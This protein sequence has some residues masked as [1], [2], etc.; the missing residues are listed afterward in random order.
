MTLEFKNTLAILSFLAIGFLVFPLIGTT[1]WG[2]LNVSPSGYA[3]QPSAGAPIDW[4][5]MIG[6]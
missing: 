5:A 2:E 3:G 6:K 1:D 4:R